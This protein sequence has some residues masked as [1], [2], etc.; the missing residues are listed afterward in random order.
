MADGA[1]LTRRSLRA[2]GTW[3]STG[4]GR[5]CAP[6]LSDWLDKAGANAVHAEDPISEGWAYGAPQAEVI[7]GK[8]VESIRRCQHGRS[9][10]WSRFGKRK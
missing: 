7:A 10:S 6:I 1:M 4:N 8:S 2:T 9:L 3:T 5:T